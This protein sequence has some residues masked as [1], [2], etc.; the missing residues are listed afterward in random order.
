M[1]KDFLNLNPLISLF[2]YEWY[3]YKASLEFLK[4]RETEWICTIPAKLFRVLP[5]FW[6]PE[7]KSKP[8]FSNEHQ[9]CDSGYHDPQKVPIHSIHRS[10]CSLR[11]LGFGNK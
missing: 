7:K 1:D 3:M 9:V 2:V 4:M 5:K 8:P 11:G 10:I 6:L